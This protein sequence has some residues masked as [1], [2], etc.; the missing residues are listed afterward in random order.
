MIPGETAAARGPAYVATVMVVFGLGLDNDNR[1]V[2]V[3]GLHSHGAE[4]DGW[5]APS[6]Y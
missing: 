3:T 2:Q 1:V 5:Y 4:T 6:A